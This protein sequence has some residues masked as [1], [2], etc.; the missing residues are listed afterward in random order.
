MGDIIMKISKTSSLILLAGMFVISASCGK[1]SSIL[2]NSRV[3]VAP[4]ITTAGY[5]QGTSS[6]GSM[7]DTTR[8]TSS[9]STK[10]P[11]TKGNTTMPNNNTT[12]KNIGTTTTKPT[13]EPAVDSLEAMY[14]RALKDYGNPT[15]IMAAMKKAQAGKEVTMVALGGSITERYFA[16]TQEKCY[17]SLVAQWWKQSFPKCKLKFYNAGI[18]SSSTQMAVHRIVD[19]VLPYNPDVIIV[20]F[21]VNDAAGSEYAEYFESMLRR[22]LN[23][24]NKPGIVCIFFCRDDGSSNEEQQISIA[25]R[26][27]LPLISYRSGA[28]TLVQLGIWDWSKLSPDTIHPGDY[29]HKVAAN[30]VCRYLDDVL[31]KLPSF[32]GKVDTELIEPMTPSRF[33]NAFKIDAYNMSKYQSYFKIVSMGGFSNSTGTFGKMKYSWVAQST[34]EPFVFEV[35]GRSVMLLYRSNDPNGGVATVKV[36]GKEKGV[37]DA[38]YPWDFGVFPIAPYDSKTTGTYTV[39]IQMTNRPSSG[40]TGTNG[41]H[42]I[43]QLYWLMIDP[44]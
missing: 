13:S 28:F 31:L 37:L 6:I 8:H 44:S 38:G 41:N 33:E 29:G 30:L 17:A 16:S 32:D 7:Q 19:D 27:N 1:A 43:L 25:S 36:N 4:D 39:E 15:R 12:T 2:D 21:A 40:S 34:N 11:T 23:S 5:K 42:N 14:M 3:K 20:D 9:I 22:L 18:G 26:Y 24:A 35:K 10:T